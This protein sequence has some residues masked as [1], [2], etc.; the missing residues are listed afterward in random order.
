MS[1]STTASQM[2]D[3]LKNSLV[4]SY[5]NQI[6]G[7]FQEFRYAA[8]TDKNPK[9]SPVLH[10][11]RPQKMMPHRN[12]LYRLYS[13]CRNLVTVHR[14]QLKLPKRHIFFSLEQAHCGK[15]HWAGRENYTQKFRRISHQKLPGFCGK[16][17]SW[18]VVHFD[19]GPHLLPGFCG[20]RSLNIPSKAI[21]SINLEEPREVILRSEQVSVMLL[22]VHQA[23]PWVSSI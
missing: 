9:K 1:S 10:P 15:T 16:L 14:R 8:Q 7:Q 2:R 11:P 4:P 18:L 22:L 23:P 19:V 6:Q 21:A 12:T 20:C 17:T 3:P 5:I 13:S